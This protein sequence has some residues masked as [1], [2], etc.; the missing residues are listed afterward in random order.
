MRGNARRAPSGPAFVRVGS[1]TER[2]N[3]VRLA[4]AFAPLGRGSLTFVGDGPLRGAAR[5]PRR[6]A[7]G[8][9]A[10]RTTRCRAASAAAD[11]VCA[12]S[13][14]E[15]F[16]QSILEA[17]AAGGRWSRRA[18]AGRRS[19]CRRR[20]G[21]SSTRSTCRRSPRALEEAAAFPAPNEAARAAAAAHDV[22]RQAERVEADS[23]ASRSRSA[24]LSSTSGRDLL[25]EPASRASSS[26][27]S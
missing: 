3:V 27:C 25:L 19:S 9:R 7:R 26:A 8:R 16:G 15:P 2:K 17:M 21:S 24:S 12:P 1:L 14:L 22:R 13:L 4:D 11:V 10:F 23:A 18:S 5:G 20:P 6:R